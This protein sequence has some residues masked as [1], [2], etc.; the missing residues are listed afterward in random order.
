VDGAALHFRTT[1]AGDHEGEDMFCSKCGAKAPPGAL[2]CAMCG[3]SVALAD[4]VV[5]PSHS[6]TADTKR[7][8]KSLRGVGG[9]LGL[10]VVGLTILG[11]ILGA[12]NLSA[13]FTNAEIDY[14][15]IA[16]FAPWVSYK[17]A[18][19]AVFGVAALVSLTS[20]L[21]L[22][23]FR[24]SSV[25]LSIVALWIIGPVKVLLDIVVA[26]TSFTQTVAA[27]MVQGMWPGL[28]V[29]ILVAIIWTS[30]L[31]RSKRVRNTYY[32]FSGGEPSNRT[33]T[34]SRAA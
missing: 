27:A 2:F 30:Y 22:F 18:I 19:W 20:G 11:P 13:D 1:S 25:R 32:V 15:K 34:E 5:I 3:S 29:S 7:A 8:K 9:W 23:R 14:P 24:P 21:L 31:L 33:R 17:S 26:N 28:F 6:E 12:V 10:L 4:G 16:S